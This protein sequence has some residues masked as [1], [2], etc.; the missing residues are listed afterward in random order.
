[1]ETEARHR[2]EGTEHESKRKMPRRKIKIK[3]ETG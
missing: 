1:M 2:D 3:M